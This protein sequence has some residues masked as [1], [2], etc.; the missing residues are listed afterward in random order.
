MEHEKMIQQL[1]VINLKKFLTIKEAML[2]T[3]LCRSTIHKLRIN[4]KVK[5]YRVSSGAKS[6][7]KGVDRD[8]DGKKV[9][10]LRQSLLDYLESCSNHF[11]NAEKENENE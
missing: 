8:A 7:I 2:M 9:L 10:I 5:W 1:E 11:E 3:S 6:S 4:N